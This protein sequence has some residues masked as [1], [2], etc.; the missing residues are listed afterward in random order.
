MSGCVPIVPFCQKPLIIGE[1]V[2]RIGDR[3][4]PRRCF[5]RC[6]LEP[7]RTQRLIDDGAFV[8]C[9]E[10]RKQAPQRLRDVAVAGQTI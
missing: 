6:G 4:E 8:A 10:M 3:A 9:F 5:R 1:S 2:P 7:A